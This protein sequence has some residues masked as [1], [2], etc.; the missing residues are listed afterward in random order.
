MMCNTLEEARRKYPEFD[1]VATDFEVSFFRINSC[2]PLLL[3]PFRRPGCFGHHCSRQIVKRSTDM[4]GM[5]ND[6]Y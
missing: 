1:H 5:V 3:A 6:S 4:V 2:Y